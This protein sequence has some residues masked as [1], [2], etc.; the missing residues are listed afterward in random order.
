MNPRILSTKILSR[1][2]KE[3]LL[4]AGLGV[5]EHNFISIV[6][7]DFKVN[8]LPRN[9]IFTSKNAVKAVLD[10]PNVHLPNT[11][12]MYCVGEKTASLLKERGYTVV[13]TA[14]YG[15]ELGRKIIESGIRE[16][17]LFFCGRKRRPEMPELL[18]QNGIDLTEIEVYDTGLT[19]KK[20]DCTFDGVLFFSPSGVQSYYSLNE[21]PESVA[22]CIGETTASEAKKYSP[23]V[24]TASV[25]S[26]ENI[27]VQAIKYFK[28]H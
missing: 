8:D 7:L 12:R 21:A 9:I 19:P 23:Q 3:L 18:R 4:N 5:V 2:Q 22:F 25:P 17:F 27:V 13:K 11:V 26:I 28:Q 15:Q 1:S 24:K 16:P 14:P 6:P 20:I 10:R